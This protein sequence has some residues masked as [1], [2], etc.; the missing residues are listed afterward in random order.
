MRI[1]LIL[2]TLEA[3]LVAA[4]IMADI[5]ALAGGATV[6]LWDVYLFALLFQAALSSAGVVLL[7]RRWDLRAWMILALHAALL[8][9]AFLAGLGLALTLDP[10]GRHI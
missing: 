8:A 3:L 4:M 2:F 6:S 10:F 7:S 1:H 9:P 5:D